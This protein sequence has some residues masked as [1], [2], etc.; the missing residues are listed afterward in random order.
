MP[1]AYGHTTK[2]GNCDACDSMSSDANTGWGGF[3]DH[4]VK[5]DFRDDAEQAKFYKERR[6]SGRS[7]YWDEEE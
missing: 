7:P 3:R 2:Q 1:C 5:K 4:W 6:E